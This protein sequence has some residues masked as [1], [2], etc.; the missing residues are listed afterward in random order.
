MSPWCPEA[1]RRI[2]GGGTIRPRLSRTRAIRCL[3]HA[4]ALSLLA[5]CGDGKP[6]TRDASHRPPAWSVK[7]PSSGNHEQP[8]NESEPEHQTAI[9]SAPAATASSALREAMAQADPAAREAALDA[10][11]WQCLADDPA[12][13]QACLDGLTPGGPAACR[14]A[15]H[16]AMRLGEQD[17]AKGLAWAGSL[18]DPERTEALAALATVMAEK[19]P[20]QAVGLLGE[21]E[22]GPAK[23]RA[24]VAVA[25]RWVQREPLAAAKWVE[26][27]P[28]G[29]AKSDGLHQLVRVWG[30]ADPDS[31]V[32]WLASLPTASDRVQGLEVLARDVVPIDPE[33]ARIWLDKLS[34]PAMRTLIRDTRAAHTTNTQSPLGK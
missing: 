5:G 22:A 1:G 32:D 17:P 29:R 15:A 11:A 27:W 10:L 34:N 28:D 8:A 7:Q 19:A 12:T 25:Q 26:S 2:A 23:D 14:L 9:D 4:W 16:L 3:A 30:Q 33:A 21:L 13:A 20:E 18:D 31:M 6:D 24:Q